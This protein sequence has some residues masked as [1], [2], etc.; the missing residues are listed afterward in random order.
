[1]KLNTDWRG[2][3]SGLFLNMRWCPQKGNW[4]SQIQSCRT[5]GASGGMSVGHKSIAGLGSEIFVA[6]PLGAW[7][8]LVTMMGWSKDH[9]ES[10]NTIILS[11][12]ST[13][14]KW[15]TNNATYNDQEGISYVLLKSAHIFINLSCIS[16]TLNAFL[17]KCL[18]SKNGLCRKNSK[19]KIP[20]VNSETRTNLRY[21]TD[22]VRLRVFIRLF[23]QWIGSFPE[24]MFQPEFLFKNVEN[25]FA[26]E[27][28]ILVMIKLV[29]LLPRREGK[30]WFA[31]IWSSYSQTAKD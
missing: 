6:Y 29:V 18:Q 17:T 19:R 30:N 14:L 1:M 26:C 21:V 10:L 31:C 27:R 23:Y 24:Q 12:L 4:K 20:A 8:I 28:T 13:K 11:P 5:S 25:I 22:K 15:I 9:G 2:L 16:N 7:N 3:E